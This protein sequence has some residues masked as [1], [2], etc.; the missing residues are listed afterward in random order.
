MMEG[1]EEA[2]WPGDTVELVRMEPVPGYLR[3]RTIDEHHPIEGVIHESYLRKKDSLMQQGGRME[4]EWLP[5]MLYHCNTVA[6]TFA[7]ERF[8]Q[9]QYYQKVF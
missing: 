1:S 7:G 2:L 5:V 8:H 9:A 4:S 6:E 3:V